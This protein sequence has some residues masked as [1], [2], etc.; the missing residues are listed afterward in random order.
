VQV[1]DFNGDGKADLVGRVPDT[2]QWWVS[3]SNGA[4]GSTTLWGA[5]AP[6]LSWVDVHAARVV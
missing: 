6:S 1:G 5:W 4:T 2:G 3:V